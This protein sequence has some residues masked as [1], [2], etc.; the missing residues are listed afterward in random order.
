MMEK[1]LVFAFLF[2][3]FLGC[4]YD[5]DENSLKEVYVHDS[6]KWNYILYMAADNNLERFAIKNLHEIKSVLNGKDVNVIVLLDRAAGYDKTEGNWT[7]TRILELSHDSSLEED[8]LLELGELDTASPKTLADFLDFCKEY[9][10]ANRTILN[11]WSHGFGVYPDCKI[12][13]T[14]RSLIS[15][16]ATGYSKEDAMKIIDFCSVIRS[17]CEK[18]QEKIDILQFDC[19]YMQMIEILWELNSFVDYIVGS[20]C[21]LPANG[22][23]YEDFTKILCSQTESETAW[24]A[25]LII[26]LFQKKYENMLVSCSY[27]AVDMSNFSI[28]KQIFCNWIASLLECNDETFNRVHA[29]VQN[30]F[31]YG[32]TYNEFLDLYDLVLNTYRIYESETIVEYSKKMIDYFDK[33]VIACFSSNT[34]NDHLHGIGINL[35]YSQ[36]LFH[37]YE[38]SK[39]TQFLYIYKE[40]LLPQLINRMRYLEE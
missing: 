21:E 8:C 27:S 4:T 13:N 12:P 32:N 17:Y 23:N 24:Y 31:T 18:Y 22:G 6:V 36:Q 15:D 39:E 9:Y 2:F 20:E 34:Y 14:S 25:Q 10:P 3:A 19:C 38:D 29:L 26:D 28:W 5:K 33:N 35:P 11:I 7:T 40:S 16:Y 1:G 37:Y 30:H